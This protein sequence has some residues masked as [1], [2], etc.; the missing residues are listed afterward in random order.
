[1]PGFLYWPLNI[2]QWPLSSD[3]QHSFLDIKRNTFKIHLILGILFARQG[4]RS[5]RG[6]I[7]GA[8][9]DF[10]AL[11]AFSFC[12]RSRSSS[13]ESRRHV[14]VVACSYCPGRYTHV[15][16]GCSV[17]PQPSQAQAFPEVQ[18]LSII[19]YSK[20]I[21]KSWLLLRDWINTKQYTFHLQN[22]VHVIVSSYDKWTYPKEA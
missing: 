22:T 6:D 15:L 9:A 12:H 17:T 11:R 13:K 16:V 2:S 7:G 1:M 10:H 5:T 19:K 14:M 8:A 21:L 3:L 4:P 20:I 18:V